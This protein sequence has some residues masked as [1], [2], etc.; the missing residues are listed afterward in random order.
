LIEITEYHIQGFP[1][2]SPATS[3]MTIVEYESP[4]T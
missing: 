1:L 4:V 3:H 2:Y